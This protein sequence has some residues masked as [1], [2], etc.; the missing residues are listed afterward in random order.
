MKEHFDGIGNPINVGDEVL[1]LVPKTDASYRKGIIE[2]FK[3]EYDSTNHCEVLVS[4]N[5]GRLYC[6]KKRFEQR[7][8]DILEFKTKVIKAWRY[9]RDIIKYKA[10]Y[11]YENS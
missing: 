10:E 5:D 9:N 8:G 6:N 11:I 7:E 3:N 1:I 4:Y 2:D